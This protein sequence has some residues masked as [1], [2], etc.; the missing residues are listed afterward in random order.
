[1]VESLCDE[2]SPC[3]QVP[4]VTTGYLQ[5]IPSCR[6]GLTERSAHRG[7][8]HFA[9]ANPATKT[10]EAEEAAGVQTFLGAPEEIVY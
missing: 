6:P 10:R 2:R 9:V 5:Q 4:A 3:L 7:L 8:S 1:M